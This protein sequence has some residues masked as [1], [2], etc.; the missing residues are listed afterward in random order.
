GATLRWVSAKPWRSWSGRRLNAPIDRI[1][2]RTTTSLA[3][4]Q[5]L[6][7]G[8]EAPSFQHRPRA[9]W[10]SDEV[11]TVRPSNTA[12]ATISMRNDARFDTDQTSTAS[13]RRGSGGPALL[14]VYAYTRH[15]SSARRTRER[16]DRAFR[17]LLPP[18]RQSFYL[19]VHPGR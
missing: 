3:Q 12:M 17:A 16:V 8:L 11:Q 19:S 5:V 4:M 14:S 9:V 10:Y 2:A 1:E 6:R 7:A 15:L 18:G 13:R